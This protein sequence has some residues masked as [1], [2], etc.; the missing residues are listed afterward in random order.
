MGTPMTGTVVSE[1]NIP[2]RCAAPPAAAMR[3]RM[4][5]AA[6]RLSKLYHAVGRAMGRCDGEVVWDPEALEDFEGGSEDREI[7]IGAH[8]DHYQGVLW[9]A[10]SAARCQMMLAIPPGQP[11]DA[12]G[13]MQ[14]RGELC[15]YCRPR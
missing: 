13:P 7:R 14:H 9:V 8:R 1:A 3:T 5:R 6:S 2:G 12:A 4:P 11:K 10:G 15:G